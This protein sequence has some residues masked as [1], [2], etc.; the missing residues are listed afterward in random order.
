MPLPGLGQV[1]PGAGPS[2]SQSIRTFW[3]VA[4]AILYTRLDLVTT[5]LG[6]EAYR[7]LYLVIA[8]IV[9][10]ACLHCAFFF[11]LLWILAA[12]WDT[13]YRLFVIGGIFLIYAI[14]ALACLLYVRNVLHNRPRFLGQT[15]TELKRDAEGLQGA[16]KSK[17]PRP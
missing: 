15:L 3:R 17:G 2:L 6:E 13:Q 9:G 1:D 7:I 16:M 11:F 5:E 8:G 10:L 12:F 4:V 14:I